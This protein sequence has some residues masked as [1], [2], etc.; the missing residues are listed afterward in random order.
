M[1]EQDERRAELAAGL[2]LV[3]AA[4]TVTGDPGRDAG[5]MAAAVGVVAELPD[6]SA[7]VGALAH[8]GAVLAGELARV[9][10]LPVGVVLARVGR[11][12]AAGGPA[13]G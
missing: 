2:A 7:V 10:G 1:T 3:T 13:V 5:A 6:P 12:V 4:A 9:T 11:A 8:V